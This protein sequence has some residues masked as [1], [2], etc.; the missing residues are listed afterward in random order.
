MLSAVFL[1]CIVNGKKAKAVAPTGVAA[2]NVGIDGTDVAA[3][4]IHSLLD[5]GCE[6]KSKLGFAR[7]SN[8]KVAQL[9]TLD[10]VVGKIA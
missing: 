6:L 9:M 1:W 2:A 4:T 7:A 10:G 8:A 5:L 3:T